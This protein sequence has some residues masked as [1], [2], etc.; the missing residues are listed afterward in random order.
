MVTGSKTN[1]YWNT[2]IVS[3]WP[4][5]LT[6]NDFYNKKYNVHTTYKLCKS[7]DGSVLNM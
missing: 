5:T 4:R 1:T 6:T 7:S 3:Y 2:K